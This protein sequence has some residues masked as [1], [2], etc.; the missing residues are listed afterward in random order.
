[1]PAAGRGQRCFGHPGCCPGAR[2]EARRKKPRA[3][4]RALPASPP[5]LLHASKNQGCNSFPGACARLSH[6]FL[7]PACAPGASPRGVCQ[8]LPQPGL[9]ACFMQAHPCLLTPLFAP[10]GPGSFRHQ[11]ESKAGERGLQR[12]PG[13]MQ[14]IP[15]M[16]EH[17]SQGRA[18]LPGQ[19]IPTRALRPSQGRA[20]QPG[21]SIPARAEHPS[22]GRA[23]LPRQSIP[24]RAEHPSQSAQ[25]QQGHLRYR[26]AAPSSLCN[27]SG[28]SFLP[29]LAPDYQCPRA[30][31]Q[32]LFNAPLIIH[33]SDSKN[34]ARG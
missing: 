31:F 28:I 23:S 6:F 1:M 4:G 11:P 17:P 26:S 3:C 19:S 34:A 5:E 15:S 21:Q 22:Q 25:K 20:S 30:P 33:F 14:S 2:Q 24:A 29:Q 8:P 10:G 18:S 7:L 9:P 12:M 27:G 13:N 32:S 16:A